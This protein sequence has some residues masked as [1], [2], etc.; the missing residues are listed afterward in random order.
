MR[1]IILAVCMALS[2]SGCGAT[3]PMLAGVPAAPVVVADRTVLD[4]KAL[5]ALELLY[6]GARIIAEV[7]VDAG[8]IR[9]ELASTFA[10]L[11]DVAFKALGVARMAYRAGNAESYRQAISEGEEAIAAL[12]TLADNKE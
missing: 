5:K 3:L 4:E 10:R 2:L 12:F 1:R 6:K 7:G 9:G 11:D 8:L